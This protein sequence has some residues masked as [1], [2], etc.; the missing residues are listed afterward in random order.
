MVRGWPLSV[1]RRALCDNDVFAHV[2]DN[3][4]AFVQVNG[5]TCW[6]KTLNA[7][8]GE[9]ICGQGHSGWNEERMLVQ[10][11]APAVN[12]KFTVRVYTTLNSGAQD[13]SFAIDNVVLTNA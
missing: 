2:R 7:S 5:N 13:E 8:Q 10:C 6:T 4:K 12:G 11:T 1:A 9:Q 3:E